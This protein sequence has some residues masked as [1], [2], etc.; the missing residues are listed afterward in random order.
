MRMW[1]PPRIARLRGLY[2]K[3]KP[4]RLAERFIWSSVYF[5]VFVMLKKRQNDNARWGGALS[6]ERTPSQGTHLSLHLQWTGLQ[7]RLCIVEHR[8]HIAGSINHLTVR[9]KRPGSLPS[10]EGWGHE[11]C[12]VRHN[13]LRSRELPS[14][15]GGAAVVARGS[16]ARAARASI[17]WHHHVV[18]LS[19]RLGGCRKVDQVPT[20]GAWEDPFII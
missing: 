9:E 18:S 20:S 6:M 4:R 1:S 8:E 5:Y 11:V 17:S 16:H 10:F 14:D 7:Y 12:A 13:V 15:K 2:R 19:G 3:F